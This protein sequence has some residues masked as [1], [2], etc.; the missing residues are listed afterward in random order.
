[1]IILEHES[2]REINILRSLQSYVTFKF[3]SRIVYVIFDI[4]VKRTRCN[5]PMDI[6]NGNWVILGMFPDFRI[7]TKVLYECAG[8]FKPIGATQLTCL[9]SG[10]WSDYAPRCLPKGVFSLKLPFNDG[11]DVP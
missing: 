2:N 3:L 7:F 6:K 5:A 11:S 1:M 9:A 4:A 8:D 10:Y